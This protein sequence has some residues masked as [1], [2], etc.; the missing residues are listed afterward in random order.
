MFTSV[1]LDEWKLFA[2][3]LGLTLEEI[4]FLD[5]RTLNPVDATL[6]HIAQRCPL[7]VGDLYDLLNDC[8]LP[9]IADELWQKIFSLSE[10]LVS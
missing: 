7:T 6:N 5:Q 10:I 2:E 4:R 3:K 1:G 8:E 9:V